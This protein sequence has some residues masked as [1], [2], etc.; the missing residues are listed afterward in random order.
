M[1]D[2]ALKEKI[3]KIIDSYQESGYVNNIFGRQL[4]AKDIMQ[5]IN[6]VGVVMYTNP[7]GKRYRA[8]NA[9]HVDKAMGLVQQQEEHSGHYEGEEYSVHCQNCKPTDDKDDLAGGA[10]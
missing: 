10:F 8:Y 3:T 4:C 9:D 7:D 6:E 5:L 1:E 2:K